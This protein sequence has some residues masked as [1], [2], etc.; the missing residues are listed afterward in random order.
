MG[1][2]IKNLPEFITP[3]GNDYDP[4]D[5]LTKTTPQRVI[6]YDTN[7]TNFSKSITGEV[8]PGDY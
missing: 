8:G 3:A 4:I 1:R 5:Y 7:R 6:N 2:K